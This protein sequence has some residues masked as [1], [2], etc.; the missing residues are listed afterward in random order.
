MNRFILP[1][2]S[3][4][5]KMRTPINVRAETKRN[6]MKNT[7]QNFLCMT[8]PSEHSRKNLVGINYLP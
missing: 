2:N 5:I 3:W 4:H 7:G 8:Q 1:D 6:F